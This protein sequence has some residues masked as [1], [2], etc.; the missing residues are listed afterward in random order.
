MKQTNY[1]N[2]AN[3]HIYVG[4]DV[5]AKR[6]VVSIVVGDSLIGPISQDP[7]VKILVNYLRRHFPGGNYHCVYEAG[8]SG[9]WIHDELKKNGLNCIVINP[10]DI[11]TTHKEKDRKTDKR[12]S[13]KLCRCHSHGELEGIYVH[14]KQT[15]E[16]RS[17]IRARES[18]VKEQTR[19]KNRIKGLMKFF[20]I[21]IT[22]ED[23]KTHW[24][25]KFLQY[26][27][28]LE[29]EYSWAKISLSTYLEELRY[30]RKLISNITKEIRKLSRT[31]RYRENVNLLCTIPGISILTA[32]ILLTE[33]WDIQRFANIDKLCSFIGL[34]PSEHSSGEK[35]N[36]NYMTC[37][38]KGILKRIIIESSWTAIRKDSGLLMSFNQLSRRM[39]KS[40]AIIT[41]SRKLV[42]RIMYVLNHK[43]EYKFLAVS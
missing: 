1:L 15:Y 43:E 37:R 34:V 39:K 36:R 20:G 32:M 18:L 13:R 9:F 11:P 26:L 27:E 38:G 6:W 16:E 28:N 3:Q 8:F 24:S 17:I 23:I 7:E 41:I 29:T 12:D 19:C 31:E 40:R 14:D 4:I 35:E 33:L 42:G 25:N 5:H 21:E 22:D 10:A 30:Y 2:F